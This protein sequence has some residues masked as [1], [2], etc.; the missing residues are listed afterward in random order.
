MQTP[1]SSLETL[2]NR[3]TKL[4]AQ[5]RRLKKAGIASLVVFAAI[6]AMGQMPAKKVIEA[7]GFV[8]TDR[9]GRRLAELVSTGDHLEMP[10]MRMYGVEP[11]AKDGTV[12]R[13][14]IGV[15]PTP[16]IAVY[17]AFGP[18]EHGND[19]LM[20]L[21]FPQ[22]EPSLFLGS[23]WGNL[24]GVNPGGLLFGFTEDGTPSLTLV[25]RQGYEAVL[26]GTQ[27]ASGG[28]GG[29]RVR[30]A[31]SLVLSRKDKKVLWSAP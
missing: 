12:L 11:L 29:K 17:H 8:L 7:N 21:L 23:G 25:D 9:N 10:V 16:E 15:T 3:V 18:M 5:N 13:L 2:A 20:D 31:A 4:E 19:R 26:G 22:N 30:S 1:E 14:T 24:S 28:A 6:I 27:L